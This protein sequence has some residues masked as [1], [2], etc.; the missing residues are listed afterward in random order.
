MIELTKS[1][2]NKYCHD[3]ECTRNS[4][5]WCELHKTNDWKI[6][7]SNCTELKNYFGESQLSVVEVGRD[8]IFED[9]MKD[10][11]ERK[12]VPGKNEGKD[13]CKIISNEYFKELNK[14]IN[15]LISQ[16]YKLLSHQAVP[17]H[18]T[19]YHFATLVIR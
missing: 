3:N 14:E 12:V 7:L 5:G 10:R 15:L 2:V 16:G 1:K 8:Y 11:I 9:H 17:Q 19:I 4:N 6:K 13:H 18:N